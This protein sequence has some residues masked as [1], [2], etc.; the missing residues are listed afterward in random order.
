MNGCVR[1]VV[2]LHAEDGHP[3]VE[4]L[5]QGG[6]GAELLVERLLPLALLALEVQVVGVTEARDPDKRIDHDILSQDCCW[7]VTG[8]DGCCT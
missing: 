3:A 5:G 8:A 2:L 4:E 1:E 6:E 7:R